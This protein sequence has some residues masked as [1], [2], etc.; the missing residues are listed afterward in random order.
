VYSL[1]NRLSDYYKSNP[2][3]EDALN[4]SGIKRVLVE[5][6]GGNRADGTERMCVVWIEGSRIFFNRYSS[7]QSKVLLFFTTFIFGL[8]L[9]RARYANALSGWM[10][11]RKSTGHGVIS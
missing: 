8:L 6:V 2:T 5:V 9:R 10:R 3:R 11:K 1:L 4:S 7:G